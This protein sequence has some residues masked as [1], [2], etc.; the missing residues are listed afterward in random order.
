MPAQMEVLCDACSRQ[1]QQHPGHVIVVPL[2]NP[3]AE[4]AALAFVGAVL[5]TPEEE[6]AAD[7][8]GDCLLAA[9]GGLVTGWPELSTLSWAD[10]KMAEVTHLLWGGMLKCED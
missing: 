3:W 7:E 9:M 2:P 4:L 6:A 5:P 10:I 8:L 1:V